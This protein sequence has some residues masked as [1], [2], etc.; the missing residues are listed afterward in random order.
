MKNSFPLYYCPNNLWLCL[1][2]GTFS[3]ASLTLILLFI[4]HS[5][6]RDDRMKIRSEKSCRRSQ[7]HVDEQVNAL[8]RSTAVLPIQSKQFNQVN[9]IKFKPLHSVKTDLPDKPNGIH[10][11]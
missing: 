9:Q 5:Y 10:N 4:Y 7:T 1:S 6:H 11:R 8:L 3:V 2:L